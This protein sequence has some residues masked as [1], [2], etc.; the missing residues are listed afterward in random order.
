VRIVDISVP[1]RANTPTWP[2]SPKIL[3]HWTKRLDAG[4]ECNN[5]RLEC[6]THVGTHVDA[7]LHFLAEGTSVD[8]L[9]LEML[10]GPAA[11]AYLPK[12][13]AVTASE[14]DKLALPSGTERLLLRTNNSEFWAAGISE[15]RKDYVSLTP[16]AA[17]WIVKQ[18]IQL[19]GV[20]Y[21]SVGSYEDGVTTH[22]I[23]LEAGVVV[24]EGLNLHEVHPGEYQLIC[25]PLK[26]VGAEGA[27]ARAVL[28][29]YE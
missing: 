5:T 21:L 23:L 22:R 1:L 18:G 20:D 13:S 2:G 4:D 7:P 3:L 28:V 24:V 15:F 19:V 10:V 12:V 25:L 8:K 6:D 26:L 11:V 16:D 27:P 14:L 17:Q 9:S 29:R